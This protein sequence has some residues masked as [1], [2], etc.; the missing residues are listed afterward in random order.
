MIFDNIFDDEPRVNPVFKKEVE[1]RP[2]PTVHF[3][4]L[5]PVSVIQPN[6]TNGPWIAGGACL[7]WYQNLPVADTDI[8]IF[9]STPRQC[10]EVI[11]RIKSY[12][13][14]SVKHEKRCV[15]KSASNYRS[16]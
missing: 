3:K 6:V 7:R 8:D 12:G 11:D 4:D 14:Y 13:R 10:Q 15:R 9:C 2:Y 16:F 1:I 5:E